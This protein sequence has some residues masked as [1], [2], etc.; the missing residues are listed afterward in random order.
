VTDWSCIFE[1]EPLPG[2]LNMAVDEVLFRSLGDG[3]RTWLRFYTWARPTASL[4]RNQSAEEALDAA[5]CRSLGVDIVRR[6]T[7]GKLVL[8]HKELTYSVC[9]SDTRLFPSAVQASYRLISMGLTRGLEGLGL[10]A[11][12]AAETPAF[13][14]HGL[15]PCFAGPAA[16]EIEAGGRKVVGSAQKRVGSRFLQ[17]GSVP[18]ED[19]TGLLASFAR[20]APGGPPP[21]PSGLNGL[22]GREVSFG[23]LAGHLA[24]GLAAFFGVRL[25]PTAL[26]PAQR[27]E[28]ERIRRE[29]YESDDWTLR[30]AE[31]PGLIFES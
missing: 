31:P 20:S 23:E 21:G 27:D 8:H 4:G 9:S 15:H 6:I 7:G 28:A 11:A 19:T 10:E 25:V 13:Y 1:P 5:A 14:K 2:A 16:D 30:G 3:P 18:L 17:H 24:V 22:L 12:L 26:T 29:R